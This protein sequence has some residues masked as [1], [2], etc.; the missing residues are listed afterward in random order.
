MKQQFKIDI[1]KYVIT[2]P[3]IT[4]IL[5]LFIINLYLSNYGIIDYSIL[6]SHSIYVGTI[7]LLLITFN[8]IYYNIVLNLYNSKKLKFSYYILLTLM[9]TIF[10]SVVYFVFIL[11]GLAQD[12]ILFNVVFPYSIV[13]LITGITFAVLIVTLF[14]SKEEKEDN[15]KLLTKGETIFFI[16]LYCIFSFPLIVLFIY[17]SMNSGVFVSIT[18]LFV[19]FNIYWLFLIYMYRNIKTVGGKKPNQKLFILK[20]VNKIKK[21]QPYVRFSLVFFTIIFFISILM[22]YSRFVYPHIPKIFGGGKSSKMII[23]ENKKEVVGRIIYSNKNQIFVLLDNQDIKIVQLNNLSKM[24]CFV[25][26]K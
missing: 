4:S 1:L 13:Q 3:I 8:I 2:I 15:N 24:K 10:I 22:Y 5:G 18:M 9:Q 7:F 12:V 14:S 26:E 16:T 19:Q 11:G 21:A 20:L 25:N 23:I 6:R 17:F